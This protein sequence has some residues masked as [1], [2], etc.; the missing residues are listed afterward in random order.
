MKVTSTDSIKTGERE[1][2]DTVIADLD[3]NGIKQI[4]EERYR[5]E[6]DDIT[7]RKGDLTVHHD[8]VAYK[9]DFDLSMTL[10]VTLDRDGNVLSLG[11]DNPPA[12]APSSE[13][14]AAAP[15]SADHSGGDPVSNTGAEFSSEDAPSA[16]P[17]KAPS[18]NFSKMA[19]H[20]ANMISE[21][22]DD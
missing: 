12:Q 6:I 4:I 8:Q 14:A 11:T 3:K 5:F 19:S 18:E 1:L 22:N 15:L 10:S 7:Y 2:I 20:I 16:D 9:L 17:E 13:P 21:I